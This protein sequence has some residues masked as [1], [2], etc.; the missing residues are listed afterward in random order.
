MKRL[1]GKVALIS[2]ATSGIGKA[3]AVLFAEE[4]AKVVF[5]G[6]RKELGDKIQQEI[7]AAGGEAMFVQADVTKEEDLKTLVDKA[8]ATY[9]GIDVLV[10]NAGHSVPFRLEEMDVAKHY[11]AVFN[12]NIKSYF[13]LTSLAVRPML[14]KGKGSI[15][16][17]ASL[18]AIEGLD[19]YASYCA[20]KGAVLQ[21]TRALAVEYAKRGIRVNSVLPGLTNTELIPEGCDFEK[22][23]LPS[24]PMGRSAK[25][26]E[27][28]L[29]ALFLASDEASYCTGVALTVDG[30]KSVL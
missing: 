22:L 18:A 27:V 29:A 5:C 12:L 13:M 28:A 16:N 10:N 2:G 21:F 4:G 11:D 1:D 6:R 14:K 20:S 8:V 19:Q 30:G 17:T 23:V 15:V 25:P 24:V 7:K 26:R 9:G 3:I